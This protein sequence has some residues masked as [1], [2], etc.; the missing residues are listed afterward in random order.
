MGDSSQAS[1]NVRICVGFEFALLR[2]IVARSPVAILQAVNVHY[3]K[4]YRWRQ[5]AAVP[6]RNGY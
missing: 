4:P 2:L 5:P 6:V 3:C 1:K